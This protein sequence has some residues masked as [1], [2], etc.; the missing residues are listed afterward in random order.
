MLVESHRAVERIDARIRVHGSGLARRATALA[1]HLASGPAASLHQVWI[2]LN[3]GTDIVPLPRERMFGHVSVQASADTDRL[4]VRAAR[5][6]TVAHSTARALAGL[7]R[8]PP[9]SLK[10]NKMTPRIMRAHGCAVDVSNAPGL[11]EQV[12]LV[13]LILY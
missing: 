8:E 2:S 12:C 5:R 7:K 9:G 13:L 6:R 1:N 3:I 11:K 4:C 10:Q